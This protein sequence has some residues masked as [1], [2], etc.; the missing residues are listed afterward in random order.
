MKQR[1]RLVRHIRFTALGILALVLLA[2]TGCGPGVIKGRPPFVAI[3]DMTLENGSLTTRYDLSNQNG[4]EMSIDRA[5]ITV[6]SNA[7]TLTRYQSDDRIVIDANSTE[8]IS[9]QELP[10]EFTR[11]LLQSLDSGE[12]DSLSF[13][14]E[15][16]VLTREDGELRFE[17][18]GYL[19]RVPGRPGQFRSAVTQANELI[20]EDPL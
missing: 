12:L 20:R 2:A 8:E 15:G 13:E 6:R 14:L 16:R 7:S 4:A 1:I 19:Y 18:K 11:T 9:T 17:Q 3:S 10:A 5:S